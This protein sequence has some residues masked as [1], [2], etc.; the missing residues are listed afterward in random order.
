MKI[1]EEIR[2]GGYSAKREITL[3]NDDYAT[4]F[5]EVV[6]T[7]DYASSSQYTNAS[8][9]QAHMDLMTTGHGTHGWIDWTDVRNES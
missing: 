5:E 4:F 2:H 8:V 1:Y 9:Q 3:T 7:C 6:K